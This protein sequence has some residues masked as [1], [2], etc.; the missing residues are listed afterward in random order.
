VFGKKRQ[1]SASRS[2]SNA[3]G[4]CH[5]PQ[6]KPIDRMARKLRA[7]YAHNG[8]YDLLEA[9]ALNQLSVA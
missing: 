6:D 7:T 4:C 2:R 1:D 5:E 3:T 8:P 9:F